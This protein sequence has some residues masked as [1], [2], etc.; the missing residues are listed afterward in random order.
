MRISCSH[1]NI[2]G[3]ALV[4]ISIPALFFLPWLAAALLVLAMLIVALSIWQL[5]KQDKLIKQLTGVL[6]EAAAGQM[7]SRITGIGHA[8]ELGETCW[9]ANDVLDQLEAV[10]RSQSSALEQLAQHSGLRLIQEK[11]LHGQFKQAAAHTNSAISL[12]ASQREQL[13]GDLFYGLLDGINSTGLLNNLGRSHEDLMEVAQVVDSLS[14]FAAQ[15]AIAAKE[16]E[17]KSRQATEH[18]EQLARQSVE[19]EQAVNHLHSEGAKALGATGQID[20]IA[21]K[22]NLL[23]LNAAIEAARAG[24]AGRGF[25]V[26]ADEVRKLSVMTAVFSSNIRNSLSA[27][28]E[29]A[30]H[31]KLAAQAMNESMQISLAS[32]YQVKEQLDHVSEAASTSSTSSSLAK[33]LT[34]ASLAKIDG[35]TMKQVAYR[36]AREKTSQ[37]SNELSLASIDALAEQLPSN[38]R[39]KLHKLAEMLMASI[40][41]ALE[42]VREGHRDTSAFE[43]ME[44]A[45]QNLTNAIDEALTEARG[46]IEVKHNVGARID[47]F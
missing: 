2:I 30:A 1:F 17:E 20:D 29:D 25:A 15:S 34:V 12:I 11:G 35:F 23:A 5:A 39:A 21:K 13:E 45:N 33:S 36:E 7:E 38:H 47:L 44:V 3:I 6:R 43:Q 42:S 46:H 32:T 41:T 16:G 40:G 8:G 9:A 26:V 37:H 10:F 27:V 19:L 18:I 4:A 28:A 14:A 31:M 22:V 24:E